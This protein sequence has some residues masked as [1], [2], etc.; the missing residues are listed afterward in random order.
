[1]SDRWQDLADDPDGEDP[2]PAEQRPGL[3]GALARYRNLLLIAGV[4]WFGL[5]LGGGIV[6]SS[7][8]ARYGLHVFGTAEWVA[9]EPAV[10]R[11][12]LRDLRFG[13][14]QP[15]GPMTVQ[16]TDAEGN[17]GPTQ[18][19]A[20]PA[21]MFVQG[22]ITAPGRAGTW[23]VR[24]DA[25][26]PDGQVTA[27]FPITV[28]PEAPRYTWPDAPKP[29][30]PPKPDT[31]PLELD[32][33]PIDQALP[34]GLPGTL[35]VRAADAD[36]QPLSTE[37]TLETTLGRSAKAIPGSVITD[38]YGLATIDVLPMH[39][40][41]DFVLRAG[42][43]P[44]EAPETPDGPAV[45]RPEAPPAAP[46]E[47]AEPVPDTRTVAH[48]RVH[49][50]N[51]QFA[52]A[53]PTWIVPPEG[54]LEAFFKSLHD[55]IDVFVDV[56]HGDRWLLASTTRL[57]QNAGGVKL[58]LPRLPAD[59]TVV[60]V[61]V[62]Q[63]TYMPGDA[64]AGRHVIVSRKTPTELVRWAAENLGEKGFAP[65]TMKAHAAAADGNL[66]LLRDLLGRLPRP[67]GE[68]PLLVDSG[69]AAKQTVAEMKSV[70]ENRMV[71][72]LVGSGVILFVIMGVLIIGNQRQVQ[73]GWVEAGGAEEGEM[74][75]TRKRLLLDAGYMFIVLAL[76]LIGMIQL[77]L[78]I[79]W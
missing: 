45:E 73:R 40:V 42:E 63:N 51:T 46:A 66:R 19:L 4:I 38:R 56:W 21:G 16:L 22:H 59:P 1:M 71:M 57:R 29:K 64:R 15:M 75:G 30:H 72:A 27:R 67:A 28:V 18:R 48:R 78:A 74:L 25:E 37:V 6:L 24:I 58:T 12:A 47:G 79:R 41:F 52:L 49:H 69:I 23:Q 14:Y 55:D 54:S 5:V 10:V 50:T 44:P 31:G 62:L 76:F 68:P 20:Q 7:V 65:S 77:L 32:V 70:W 53:V 11:A 36:G 13:R 8:D 33:K 17:P 39:P 60:W 35:V 34:G 43:G 9:G 3:I 2:A 26:G 61:Q